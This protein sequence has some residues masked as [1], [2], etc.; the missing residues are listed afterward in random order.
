[1]TRRS[2]RQMNR[3]GSTTNE[4]PAIRF[5]STWVIVLL[6]AVVVATVTLVVTLTGQGQNVVTSRLLTAPTSAGWTV[7]ASQPST[8]D[9]PKSKCFLGCPPSRRRISPAP[10]YP[11]PSARG[12]RVLGVSGD[13][14]DDHVGL[15]EERARLG[16][17]PFADFHQNKKTIQATISPIPLPVWDLLRRPTRCGSA[18]QAS[19]SLLISHCSNFQVSRRGHLLRQRSSANDG[20]RSPGTSGRREGQWQDR[21]GTAIS[22][23]SVPV[24]I[25][26]TTMETLATGSSG[27]AR[28]WS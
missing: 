19:P 5:T 22:I 6:T 9:L 26:H 14:R 17:M 2:V 3:D 15:R 23:V 7:V 28:R 4:K 21:E 20:P 16:D 1:V 13:W 18:S 10:R 25:A 12:S 27:A 8:L 11:S 24:L